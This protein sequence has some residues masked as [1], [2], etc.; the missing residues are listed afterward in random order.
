MKLRVLLMLVV[1]VAACGVEVPAPPVKSTYD[2]G[3]APDFKLNYWDWGATRDAWIPP[4]DATVDSEVDSTVDGG[5]NPPKVECEPACAT[6]ELCTEA[7]GAACAPVIVLNGDATDTSVL[8]AITM[9]YIQCW[10]YAPADDK[11]CGTFSTCLLKTALTET[12]VT[13]WVCNQAQV[14]DFP[15]ADFYEKAQ[16]ICGCGWFDKYRPRWDAGELLPTTAGSIC[17][18]YDKN[19]ILSFDRLAVDLCSKF[20][21]N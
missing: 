11:L 4:T 6:G 17:L 2:G 18:G 7:S 1:F 9:A 19:W 12:A 21:H 5:C 16:T 20:P 15:S 14:V 13:D 3:A 8:K 10:E